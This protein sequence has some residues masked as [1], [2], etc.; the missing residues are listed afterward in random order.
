MWQTDVIDAV[1]QSR[2]QVPSEITANVLGT[3]SCVFG[4]ERFQKIMLNQ[5]WF[6]SITDRHEKIAEAHQHTFRWIYH[7]PDKHGKPWASFVDWLQYGNSIYWVTEKAGSGKSTL[8][9]YLY[10]HP[11][12]RECL[13]TWAGPLSFKDCRLLLLEFWA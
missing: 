2:W 4:L 6:E 7:D 1:Y 9:K 3:S 12:A 13:T 8:L 11:H 10:D 5:L